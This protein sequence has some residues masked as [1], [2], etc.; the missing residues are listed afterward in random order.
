MFVLIATVSKMAGIFVPCVL[1]KI[2]TRISVMMSVLMSCK[3][4]VCLIVLNYGLACDIISHKLFAILVFMVLITTMQTIP[5]LEFV[6]PKS[7]A[8]LIVALMRQWEDD[9]DKPR[10]LGEARRGIGLLVLD[11]E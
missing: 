2:P 11:D 6:A 5:L 4:L 9:N 10:V 7:K 1:L 3:G 8:A